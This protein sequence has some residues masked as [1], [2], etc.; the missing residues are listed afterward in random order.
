[1][2]YYQWPASALGPAE[3]SLLF[4]ARKRHPRRT[5]IAALLADAV[6]RVYGAVHSQSTRPEPLPKNEVRR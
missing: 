3:M 4:H 6:R 5:T 1:M 2:S